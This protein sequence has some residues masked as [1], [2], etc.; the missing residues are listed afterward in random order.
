MVYMPFKEQEEPNILD[1][2][3]TQRNEI[4]LWFYGVIQY[5]F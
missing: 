4:N 5:D 1:N 2:Y 3:V